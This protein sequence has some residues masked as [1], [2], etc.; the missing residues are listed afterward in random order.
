MFML[1]GYNDISDIG[2]A[3]FAKALA[4]NHHL[5][6]LHLGIDALIMR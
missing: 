5:L 3:A 2:A 6:E 4:T 1:S